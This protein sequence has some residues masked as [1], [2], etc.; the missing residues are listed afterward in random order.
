MTPSARL[1]A[2]TAGV[3]FVN[4][5]KGGLRES[6]SLQSLLKGV[7]GLPQFFLSDDQRGHP[8]QDIAAGAGLAQ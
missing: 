7:N 3:R 4:I 1:V 2:R 5:A 8:R 6:Q